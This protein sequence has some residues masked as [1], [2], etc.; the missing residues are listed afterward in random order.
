MRAGSYDTLLS[1]LSVDIPDRVSIFLVPPVSPPDYRP[2]S[3]ADKG[4]DVNYGNGD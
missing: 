1:P 2:H 4:W 3:M